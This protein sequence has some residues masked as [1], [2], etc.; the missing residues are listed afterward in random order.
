MEQLDSLFVSGRQIFAQEVISDEEIQFE[1]DFA[2]ICYNKDNLSGVYSW[3]GNEIIPFGSY[4]IRFRRPFFEVTKKDTKKIEIYTFE[5]KKL[6]LE[7]ADKFEWNDNGLFCT[8]VNLCYSAINFI[9]AFKDGKRSALYTYD[10]TK[11]I[12]E[13]EKYTKMYLEKEYIICIGTDGISMDVYNFEGNK[14]I[15]YKP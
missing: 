11:V 8:D 12:P 3:E 1:E 15:E 10:G 9:L 7:E 4:W 5:G 6:P 13:V 14:I 2:F